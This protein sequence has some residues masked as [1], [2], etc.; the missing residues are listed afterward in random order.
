[1]LEGYRF[2]PVSVHRGVVKA[3]KSACAHA[4]VLSFQYQ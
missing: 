3:L 1:V 2:V 4:D